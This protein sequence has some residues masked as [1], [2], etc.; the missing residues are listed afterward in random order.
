MT[1]KQ[2]FILSTVLV[3]C[4][5][6][7]FTGCKTEPRE[8]K[9]VEITPKLAEVAQRYDWIEP[10]YNG[11]ARCRLNAGESQ[12]VDFINTDGDLVDINGEQPFTIIKGDGWD[13]NKKGVADQE[14]NVIIP[15]E[16]ES[17]TINTEDSVFWLEKHY[18]FTRN[19]AT[20]Y[21]ITDLQG[22]IKT[23]YE[24]AGYYDKKN[25]KVDETIEYSE[26][27]CGVRYENEAFYID[28]Q[29][30]KVLGGYNWVYPFRDGMAMVETKD[31]VCVFIDH[32]GQRLGKG[33]TG[34][35]IFGGT[36]DDYREIVYYSHGKAIFKTKNG[37]GLYDVT[38]DRMTVNPQFTKLYEIGGEGRY[39]GVDKARSLD[40]I[41]RKTGVITAEGKEVLPCKFTHV[42]MENNLIK[43]AVLSNDTAI[44]NYITDCVYGVYNTESKEVLPLKFSDVNIYEN[45]IVVT[46]GR[47]FMGLYSH[48]GKELMACKYFHIGEESELMLV[49]QKDKDG[50]MG[51]YDVDG[52]ER[53]KPIYDLA[54]SFSE[55]LAFVKKNGVGGFVNAAG[56]DTYGGK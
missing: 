21:Y 32:Q 19:W 6:S 55:G 28:R 31:G 1:N 35:G 40:D 4:C 50:P 8:L 39:Y 10:F 47:K 44:V 3:L 42:G 37:Y 23:Q 22:N 29:G 34:K 45:C 49:V 5:G 41:G 38:N 48:E 53:I 54:G 20:I 33:L 15:A 13:F 51:Y 36:N 12:I 26:G 25:N 7:L 11:I 9:V 17:I 24:T 52:L 2:L 30:N 46:K 56:Q 14:G 43:V 18:G 16:Y 27:F